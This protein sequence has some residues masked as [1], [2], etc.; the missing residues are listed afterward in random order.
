MAGVGVGGAIGNG[1]D[2]DV[3][4]SGMVGGGVAHAGV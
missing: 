1:V 4:E 2:D 3:G